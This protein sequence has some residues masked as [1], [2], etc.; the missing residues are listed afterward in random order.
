MT[1]VGDLKKQ[2]Q[3]GDGPNLHKAI[4]ERNIWYL[5]ALPGT[6]KQ[7]QSKPNLLS[8]LEDGQGDHAGDGLCPAA[9][10]YDSNNLFDVFISA[11][12][13]F[14]DFAPVAGDE[15]YALHAAFELLVA[16]Q[17][18]RYDPAPAGFSASGG[19]AHYPAG[20]VVDRTEG[21]S[22]IAGADK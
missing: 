4:F 18:G 21:F 12:G 7:S 13:F 15:L 14:L 1:L 22:G 6:K 5:T 17:S 20:T 3:F 11:R 9:L 2:T 16:N 19:T 10:D 8:A